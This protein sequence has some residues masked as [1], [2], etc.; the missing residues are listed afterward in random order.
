M[1]RIVFLPFFILLNFGPSFYWGYVGAGLLAPL[2]WSVGMAIVN[3][4]SGRRTPGRGIVA[5]ALIGI[6]LATMTSVPIYFIGRW[7]GDPTPRLPAFTTIELIVGL[8]IYG[9]FALLWRSTPGQHHTSRKRS[10][11]TR[12][13]GEVEAVYQ[14]IDRLMDDE[15][16]QV[17]AL[18]EPLRSKVLRGASCD[19]IPGA[20]GE[21]GRDPRNPIPVNG[22][23]GEIIYLSNLRTVTL[24]PIMFHRL[25]SAGHVDVYETVSVDG[26]MWD[27]LFFDLYHPRKSRRTPTGYQITDGVERNR[28][29]SGAYEFVAAFPDQLPGAIANTTGRLFGLR[30]RPLRVREAVERFSFDRPAYHQRKFSSVVAFLTRAS[31]TG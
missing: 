21:F 12:V 18:P 30:M 11:K 28:L 6:C 20:I 3:I 7:F 15:R 10:R 9:S 22:P 17:D 5:S 13:S 24:D 1:S 25:G 16:A 23:M 29:L 19:E 26:A 27:V 4:A 14:E 2:G 8:L 31:A